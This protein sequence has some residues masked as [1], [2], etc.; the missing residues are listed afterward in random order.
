VTRRHRPDFYVAAGDGTGETPAGLEFVHVAW[1]EN[2]GVQ[3]APVVC[4]Q[5]VDD[6]AR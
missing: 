3:L 2:N 4:A 5:P 6:L 1:L